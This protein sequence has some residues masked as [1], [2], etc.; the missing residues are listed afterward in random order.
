MEQIENR[1]VIDSEWDE[2]EYRIPN[3]SRVKRERQAYEAAEY[4]RDVENEH[5]V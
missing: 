2:C 1:M 4:G 3:K 5:V